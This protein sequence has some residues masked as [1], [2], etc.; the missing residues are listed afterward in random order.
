MVLAFTCW[1]LNVNHVA[2]G[3]S[4]I[5]VHANT[6]MVVL[7]GQ[8][9]AAMQ[10]ESSSQDSHPSA[11]GKHSY[12]W[13]TLYDEFLPWFNTNMKFDMKVKYFESTYQHQLFVLFFQNTSIEI[14]LGRGCVRVIESFS[15]NTFIGS[16]TKA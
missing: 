13:F 16:S 14:L 1:Y 7:I 15:A 4:P 3:K 2:G 5:T 9:R 11:Q 8:F 10:G 6:R 12:S